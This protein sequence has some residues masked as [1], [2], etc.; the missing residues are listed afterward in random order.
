MN[1]RAVLSTKQSTA[2][3]GTLKWYSVNKH[4][5][6]VTT[7]ELDGDF[8]L[9][10]HVLQAFGR[11]SLAA[12]STI[13]FQY[14]QSTNGYRVTKIISIESSNPNSHFDEEVAPDQVSG[15]F[16][17]ARVK[18]FDDSRGY[19]F[20]NCYGDHEDVFL[21]SGV[22]R[23]SGLLDMRIGEAISVQVAEV[24]G[25]KRV[26]RIDDWLAR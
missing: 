19:G 7:P 9:H 17:P 10:E 16:V 21:G 14:E 11:S 6:F 22:L 15:G 4:M 8:L 25:R 18:W 12:G 20:V 1:V 5:G 26:Y 23:R 3:Q 13:W 2:I 24:K